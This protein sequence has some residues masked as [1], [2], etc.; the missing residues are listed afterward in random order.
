MECIS[1]E[2]P[3]DGAVLCVV[4]H[5]TLVG[6]GWRKKVVF[7]HAIFDVYLHKERKFQTASLD[8]LDGLSFS[9]HAER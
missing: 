1:S 2:T 5:R 4:Y 6:G 8:A 3:L 9:Q 7:T